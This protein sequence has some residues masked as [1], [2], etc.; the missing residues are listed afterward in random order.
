MARW[1][2]HRVGIA[3]L[4]LLPAVSAQE[5]FTLTVRT[6]E[7]ALSF[8]AEDASGRAVTDLTAADIRLRDNGKPPQRITRFIHNQNLSLRAAI[9]FDMSNSMRYA[10]SPRLIARQVAGNLLER[11]DDQAMVVRF[12][13]ETQIQQDW[14]HDPALLAVGAAHV[15]DAG[16]TRLGGTAI[17]DTLYRIC[18]DHIPAQT[19]GQ[20]VSANAIL[21]FTDGDDNWSHARPRDVVDECA[22]RQTPIYP[23]MLDDKAR[24]DAGQKA[25]RDLAERTGGRVFY[26]EDSDAN[27]VTALLRLNQDLRD[28]Y[29]LVYHPQSLKLDNSFHTIH[30]DAPGKAFVT[31]RRGYFATP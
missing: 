10:I 31:V 17:W 3:A 1:L 20:E 12:D 7:I 22:A 28:R 29:T 9:A 21:L 27:M 18:R 2:L 26:S 24:M 23:F 4:L 30:L 15:T 8:H 13:F 11:P 25:L 5:P 6:Q 19:P 14:T 16:G